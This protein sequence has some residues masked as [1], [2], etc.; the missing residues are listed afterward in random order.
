MGGSHA[1]SGRA[2]LVRLNVGAAGVDRSGHLVHEGHVLFKVV[3]RLQT[4]G[5]A[6]IGQLV[7]T[8]DPHAWVERVVRVDAQEALQLRVS[9]LVDGTHDPVN[10]GVPIVRLVDV[11]VPDVSRGVGQGLGPKSSHDGSLELG[12]QQGHDECLLDGVG[13]HVVLEVPTV[14]VRDDKVRK[15]RVPLETSGAARQIDVAGSDDASARTICVTDRDLAMMEASVVAVRKVEGDSASSAAHVDAVVIGVGASHDPIVPQASRRRRVLAQ[16]LD[17]VDL[18]RRLVGVL[19]LGEALHELALTVRV[20]S[21]GVE[22][23]DVH[24]QIGEVRTGLCVPGGEGLVDGRRVER[25][26][27]LAGD[28]VDDVAAQKRWNP[29]QD[30]VLHD[31]CGVGLVGLGPFDL[32]MDRRAEAQGAHR[33]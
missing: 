14:G 17:L 26:V 32:R 20:R 3:A 25:D 22:R 1:C 4:V 24:G 23:G 10:A 19:G 31:V 13:A 7:L 15:V 30:A 16:R 6:E 2:P 27:S 8:V 33:V 9:A 11:D 12:L 18:S 21:S 5:V 29:P 28:A